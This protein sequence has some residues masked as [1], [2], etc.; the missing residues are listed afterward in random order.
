MKYLYDIWNK[1]C[2]H[3]RNQFTNEIV[4]YMDFDTFLKAAEQIQQRTRELCNAE[5]LIHFSQ[6]EDDIIEFPEDYENA[7]LNAREPE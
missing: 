3:R 1:Y 7:I 4:K 6:S 2:S 5:F